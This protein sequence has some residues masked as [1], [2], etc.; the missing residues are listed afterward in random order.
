MYKTW[1]KRPKTKVVE[2]LLSVASGKDVAVD[3]MLFSVQGSAGDTAYIE[4]LQSGESYT[5]IE[6]CED[7]WNEQVVSGVTASADTSDKK[8]GTASAKFVVDATPA[9]GAILG[10]EAIT[11]ADLSGKY[12][13]RLSI[14]S[15]VALSAGDLQLLLDD[16]ANCASP[17]ESLNIPAIP[18]NQWKEV[19]LALSNPSLLT[20]IISIGIKQVVDV[21]AFSLWIDD[22]RAIDGSNLMILDIPNNNSV[23][24]LKLHLTASESINVYSLNG[25]TNFVATGLEV[26]Q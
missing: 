14:K 17:L 16:T 10:S 26:S 15:S 18:A 20:A 2:T 24:S 22:V 25:T 4:L 19:Y 23:G 3:L 21:G 12:L 11:S 6:D 1:K 13:I 9:A 8:V 5:V 7:A